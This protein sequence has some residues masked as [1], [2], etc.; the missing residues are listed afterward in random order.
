MTSTQKRPVHEGYLPIYVHSLAIES[1]IDF[2]LYVFNGDELLL[3]RAAHLPFTAEIRKD[4]LENKRNRLYIS[5][6]DRRR[7][8]MH[9][10]DHIGQILTD[11]SMDD[12]SKATIVYDCAKELVQEIFADP[13]KSGS[14][15]SSQLFVESTVQYVLEQKNAFHNMLRVMS[16][17]YSVF[18][19]SVNVCTFSLALAQAA[20]IEKTNELIELGTGALLHDV[21]KAKI[22]EAILY[23]PGPLDQAEW[24]TM[25]LHPEW[26][27]ELITETDLV[28]QAAYLPIWQHHERRDGSGYPNKLVGD[29]IHI[30]GRIVAIADAFDAMT[31]KRVYRSARTSFSTLKIM[32]EQN[33]GFDHHLLQRFIR[34]MGP[35]QSVIL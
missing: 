34:L 30:Y 12:F 11:E 6:D 3:Y 25:R 8:Q 33:D 35:A 1:L 28:P 31:T 32:A 14:I 5:A 17:D 24:K 7:Y 19:H 16:F 22:P 2:D 27:V 26:G 13:T 23:K 15:R 21:G 10:K 29:D 4:L 20:G 18:S 9:I